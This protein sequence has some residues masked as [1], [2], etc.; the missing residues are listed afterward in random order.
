MAVL[1]L[2]LR[3]RVTTSS[4]FRSVHRYVLRSRHRAY[5]RMVLLTA[6]LLDWTIALRGPTTVLIFVSQT[7]DFLVQKL[8][9]AHGWSVRAASCSVVSCSLSLLRTCICIVTFLVAAEAY[10]S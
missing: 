7:T 9:P 3:V 4:A 1:E 5:G 2:L 10:N 8:F 6:M